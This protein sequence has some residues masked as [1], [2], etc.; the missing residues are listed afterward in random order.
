[1]E[2]FLSIIK[3][4]ALVF[5]GAGIIMSILTLFNYFMDV[6]AIPWLEIRFL[7]LYLLMAVTGI[8]VYMLIRFRRREE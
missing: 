2:A 1:M 6:S 3:G 4:M 8:L 5:F 7:R